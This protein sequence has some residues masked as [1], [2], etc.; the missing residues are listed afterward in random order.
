MNP[1]E[2]TLL[3]CP[4]CGTPSPREAALRDVVL[5]RCP[6]CDHCFTDV[7][8]LE[9]LGEY[10][11]AWEALHGNWFANPNVGLFDFV[12]RTI[13][14]FKPDGTVIDVGSGR[15][16]LLEYLRGALPTAELTGLD[17]SLSPDL[18][19]VE[20]IVD[21]IT[22][23]DPGDRRWD[24][25]T[26]LATIE[27]LDDVHAFARSLRA[28]LVPGGLAI[29]MT[30]NERSVPYDIARAAFRLGNPMIFER[31]YDRHHLNHFNTKSLRALF[32]RERFTVNKLLRH[33]IPLAAVDMPKESRVL[34]AGVGATFVLG[35]LTG[36]TFLQTLVL[37]APTGSIDS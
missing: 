4:V 30:N 33:N 34:R 27:H 20:V 10:D 14:E 37:T 9:Y 21:D 11:E 22:S 13:R 23:F 26:S 35:K 1:A 12:V 5:H 32:V 2:R 8:A 31:L 19:G 36:R 25:V 17:I 29:V 7:S 15:G 16:E 3:D 18:E 6:I 28:M 24:V